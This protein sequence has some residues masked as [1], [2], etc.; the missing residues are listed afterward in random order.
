MNILILGG[1]YFIGRAVLHK[2]K[3]CGKVTL[4]NRG[5]RQIEKEGLDYIQCDRKNR[6]LLKKK[7]RRVYDIVIDISAYQPEDVK[8]ILGALKKTP[9]KYIL[10]SSA[11]IYK[12]D[13]YTPPFKEDSPQGGDSIWGEY[14]VEKYQCEEQLTRMK[15]TE[16]YIIRP[17]YVYGPNNYLER[18]QF[19]WARLINRKPVLVP[20]NGETRIQF[21]FV[22][23]LAK[24]IKSIVTTDKIPPGAYNIGEN[25]TYTLNQYIDILAQVSQTEPQIEYINNQ[26][27]PARAYFP[28]RDKELT[29]DVSKISQITGYHATPFYTGLV[30][31][32]DWFAA[33]HRLQYEMTDFETLRIKTNSLQ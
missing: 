22:Y 26:S 15:N 33:N 16:V 12:R 20:G 24:F 19:I 25:K 6:D 31:T 13:H 28:F 29:L 8:N 4:L 3:G 18:E 1:T 11:A 32:F 23:D 2:I 5:T 9:Q 10:I 14:G 27:F 17:P 30:Q 21:C 7:L